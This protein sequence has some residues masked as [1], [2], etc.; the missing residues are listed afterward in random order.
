M[1][2]IIFLSDSAKVDE[3]PALKGLEDLEIRNK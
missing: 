1:S 2:H 3:N